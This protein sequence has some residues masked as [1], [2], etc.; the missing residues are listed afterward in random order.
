M[1]KWAPVPETRAC[2]LL[3]LLEE[4]SGSQS[5][6]RGWLPTCVHEMSSVLTTSTCSGDEVGW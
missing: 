2:L 5:A 1:P 3:M 4:V 6:R